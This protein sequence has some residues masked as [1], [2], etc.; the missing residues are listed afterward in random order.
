MA[1]IVYHLRNLSTL[2]GP[3]AEGLCSGLQNRV[4]RF[5]SGPGLHSRLI[6]VSK[7][8]SAKFILS[9]VGCVYTRSA[10]NKED[11]QDVWLLIF[12][13]LYITNFLQTCVAY[14][15]R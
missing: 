5:N 10:Q 6:K 11:L 4:H 13:V 7:F 15:V 9:V 8:K 12:S 2:F 1:I 3:E 14:L